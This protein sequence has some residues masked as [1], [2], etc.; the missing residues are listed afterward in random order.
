MI[1][2]NELGK[3]CRQ[4]CARPHEF[5]FIGDACIVS[6]QLAAGL[7]GAEPV[8]GVDFS[9]GLTLGQVAFL[10]RTKLGPGLW[11]GVWLDLSVVD[12][13]AS[14]FRMTK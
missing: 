12:M 7:L 1:L 14:T 11:A 9:T 8:D 6:G 13:L 5:R 2:L 3:R 10:G 4:R